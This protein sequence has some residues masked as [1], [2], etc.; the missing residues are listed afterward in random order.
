M[1]ETTFICIYCIVCVVINLKEKKVSVLILV[2]FFSMASTVKLG[3]DWERV[4]K[5]SVIV[6]GPR[7]GGPY[8][9]DDFRKGLEAV[10]G[11]VSRHVLSFGPLAK[12]S[13]WYLVLADQPSKDSLLLAQNVCVVKK[14]KEIMFRVR[15]ADKAQFTV[16]VHWAPPFVP[17]IILSNLLNNYGTVVS[18]NYEMCTAKGFEGVA[19]GVRSVVMS[20]NRNDLPHT[21][22]VTCPKSGENYQ[23]LLTIRGRKPLCLRCHEVG[24]FRR[25]CFT[26]HCR[27]CGVYGHSSESCASSKSYASAARGKGG[28]VEETADQFAEEE[29]GQT[30]EERE[31]EPAMDTESTA[32][33]E[34]SDPPPLETHAAAPLSGDDAMA[35]SD[36]EP[37]ALVT[38][39]ASDG[40]I[41]DSES[42]SSEGG[43]TTQWHVV[44]GR[45]KRKREGPVLP[46]KPTDTRPLPQAEPR[47]G[48]LVIADDDPDAKILRQ[49]TSGSETD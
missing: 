10:I 3:E 21:L 48:R 47:L 7:E 44:A 40:V 6:S 36:S 35:T 46:P 37:A 11:P 28:E 5:F 33:T 39:P 15:S 9:R 16:K 8:V 34:V 42:A 20:G 2:C 26:P 12:N 4:Q 13:E 1:H 31:T 14:G 18:M 38:A 17:N 25:D 43:D 45:Q 32:T 49:N 30:M 41:S 19:T 27:H 22:N 24:H 23:F 29:E